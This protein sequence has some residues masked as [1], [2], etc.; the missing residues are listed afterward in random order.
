MTPF[1]I[2]IA[3]LVVSLMGL[4]LIPKLSVNLNPTY[5]T[6]EISIQFSVRNADPTQVEKLATAP[7]ENILSQLRD[8]DELNSQSR[9]GS[10]NITLRFSKN[11][12]LAYKRFEVATLIRQLYPQLDE[13][14]SYPILRSSGG[15]EETE[16]STI[17]RYTVR[18]P[19][20]SYRIKEITQESI[21][22]PLQN[23][24][25]I[26][27]LPVYGANS[28]QLSIKFHPAKIEAYGLST[29][30]LRNVIQQ[31]GQLKYPGLAQSAGNEKYV[32]ILD[33][34]FSDIK[35]I[36]SLKVTNQKSGHGYRLKELADI[37][38]EEQQPNSH[39]RI[40]GE[41]FVTLTVE[42]RKGVN[43]INLAR[44]VK[45]RLKSIE[46]KLPEGIALRL[47]YDD[48]EYLEKELDKLYERSIL[49]IGIL[50]FFI[51]LINRNWRYLL[52][53]FAGIFVNVSL[54][55]IGVWA[56]D[57]EIHLYSLAGLT[58]S[59]GLIVDNA[60][61][62]IDHIHKYKNRHLFLALLAASLTTIA[63]LLLVF[64]LPEEQKMN[65]VDFSKVVALLL[66][67]SLLVALFFTPALYALLFNSFNR[68]FKG[69]SLRQLRRKVR[70]FQRYSS[71]IHWSAR[72]RKSFFVVLLLAF[73]LPIFMLPAKWEDHEWYNKIIG[74]DIYQDDIRPISD[75][76]LGGSLRLFVRNAYERSSYRQNEKTR[77][78]LTGRLPYGNT[79]EQMN[80][81]MKDF[82]EFLLKQEGIDIFTTQIYSGQYGR[83][84]IIFK[85]DYEKSAF[86]YQLKARLS[87]R[88][89]NWSGVQWS[90]YGVGQGFS[91]GS[92]DR[93][94]SF[95][96]NLKGYN[97]FEL[98]NQADKLAAMLLK[99]PR[100]QEVN[101][102]ERMSWRDQKS[103]EYI[104]RP[105]LQ[106]LAFHNISLSEFTNAIRM[107][108]PANAA[109]TYLP[110]NGEQ[111][112]VV[113]V[114]SQANNFDKFA[115]EQ[116]NLDYDGKR[117]PSSNL[118]K[119]Q[120]ESTVNAIYK[121]NR[122][123][124]RVL[125]FEYYGSSRFGSKYLD[126]V[127]A[128]YDQIKPLGYSAEE[129]SFSWGSDAAKKQYSLLLLLIVAIF[130]ICS[131]LFESFKL[132]FYILLLIP[133]SFIGLF[134]TFGWFEFYFDQGGYAAFVMLGGLTVNAGIYIL[135]DF[136]N[137]KVQN[138]RG[139]LKSVST[140]AAP[141]L[142]TIF[143]TC[144][145]LVP[146]VMNGQNEVFWFSL[147][148]G[149]IGGLIFSM[150]GVFFFFPLLAINKK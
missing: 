136:K 66:G 83:I 92:S 53:L 11:A 58:I 106:E 128:S 145:G 121:E 41:N 21:I 120:L 14:V 44:E 143:S 35:E 80:T 9:Y 10:G 122:S 1:R 76:W 130:F 67:V 73:G 111:Y 102:N 119:L 34:R 144:F 69:N 57:I 97:Y 150:I 101:T 110:I 89:T 39:Y 3:F 13:K 5:Q 38:L 134:L 59:F 129:Q 114:S 95:R 87:S 25:G 23:I 140:K 43:R 116:Y 26:E 52:V 132:P 146:F 15:D 33:Q 74:S 126:E 27:S 70:W 103:K 48:T 94:P 51:F 142:L 133:L 65:L 8:L 147:A 124:I 138:S 61:V 78:Y 93:I 60:I 56:L 37:N 131:I 104:I 149:T 90:V 98:E 45:S 137:R 49:S 85:E 36:G 18:G 55:I 86:P 109:S 47:V 148:V 113:L 141:I 88:S 12:D 40:N 50:I 139:F 79:I 31:S 64:L 107:H 96:V 63:A 82:E 29:A 75:K 24:P 20:A 135:Y 72:Y 4:A 84:E 32:L 112:P 127:L 81:I 19:F 16:N 99:H 115:L 68:N 62:M 100:I 105:D 42:A 108:A 125:S 123:Y 54:S 91:T 77:L 28:L 6:P 117:I 2:I 22:K 17:L 71:A 118:S 7:L 30:D 46:S